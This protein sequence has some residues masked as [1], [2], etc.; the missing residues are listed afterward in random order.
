MYPFGNSG[1]NFRHCNYTHLTITFCYDTTH[2]YVSISST[3]RIVARRTTW[4]R[5]STALQ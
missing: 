4:Q 3:C 5:S 2:L 1:Q